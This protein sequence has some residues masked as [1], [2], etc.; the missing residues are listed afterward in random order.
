MSNTAKQRFADWY[1]SADLELTEDSQNKRI[2]SIEELM[3]IN[4]KLFWLDIIRIYLGIEVNDQENFD[5][6]IGEF[7]NKDSI[8][9]VSGFN[10]LHKTLAG[11]LL[12]FR[13]EKPQEINKSISLAY[14]NSRFF[15]QFSS[16]LK[17]P[18]L[19]Y[20]NA[21]LKTW[22]I[23]ERNIDLSERRTE[24]VDFGERMEEDTYVV[25][26]EDQTFVTNA[27]IAL[28][29]KN[30]S[31]LEETNILWW[32][33]GETSIIL[34]EDFKKVGLPKICPI[35]ARELFDLITFSVHPVRARNIVN[36][37]LI[38][39]NSGKALSKDFTV[40]QTINSLTIDE[41]KIVLGN[42]KSD[43]EFLP[44]LTALFKSLT[45]AEGADW[46]PA[47]GG[48]LTGADFKKSMNLTSISYQILCELL[49]VK[50]LE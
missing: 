3:K 12:C 45:F 35:V 36:K 40:F 19:A 33:F 28:V 30:R 37:A 14:L 38:L 17:I 32:L 41:R 43:S 39:A 13:L 21:S 25:D 16:N 42:Y 44:C 24:I 2:E 23:K 26:L 1:L 49:L 48:K 10:N 11:I 9:P 6:F 15:G 31:L 4:D 5:K 29:D 7:K 47:L 27:I 34:S 22:A 46:T 20:C 8:F 18:V 50:N